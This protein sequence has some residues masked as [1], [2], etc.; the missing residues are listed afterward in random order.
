MGRTSEI[1]WG[2]LGF[3]GAP[4]TGNEY[5]ANGSGFLIQRS[6]TITIIGL[7]IL[8]YAL[9]NLINIQINK[10]DQQKKGLG[11]RI[12]LGATYR[13]I[14]LQFYFECL[15][16]VLAAVA[17]VFCC[18][19]IIEPFVRSMF[20]HHF[21]PITFVAMLCVSVISS[22]FISLTLFRRFRRMEIVEIVKGL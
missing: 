8:V 16:L 3:S 2:S 10:L 6:T 17:L 1:D 15:I 20:N 4:V 5:Y 11:I 21:G 12:A 18:E 14:F 19:P 7:L 22:F 13:Q 9:V